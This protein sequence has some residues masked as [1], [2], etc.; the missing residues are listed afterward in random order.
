[1]VQKIISN[2]DLSLIQK[3][4]KLENL[5]FITK[6]DIQKVNYELTEEERLFLKIIENVL[7]PENVFYWK[8]KNTALLAEGIHVK[9]SAKRRKPFVFQII[10]DFFQNFKNVY[11]KELFSSTVLYCI[12]S[13]VQEKISLDFDQKI[14]RVKFLTSLFQLLLKYLYAAAG[15]MN[16][17]MEIRTDFNLISKFSS[18]ILVHIINK[19]TPLTTTVESEGT[20]TITYLQNKN[21]TPFDSKFKLL[22]PNNLPMVVEPNQW[23]LKKKEAVSDEDRLKF[24]DEI[25]FGGFKVN[26]MLFYPGIHI[27]DKTANVTVEPQIIETIN[28]LQGNSFSIPYEKSPD[29]YEF[30]ALGLN[31]I[32]YLETISK[33]PILEIKEDGLRIIPFHETSFF[34]ENEQMRKAGFAEY[35]ALFVEFIRNLY[36]FLLMDAFK[37]TI[38]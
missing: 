14:M 31:L 15:N 23:L 4:T 27:F 11:G 7:L 26:S 18:Q 13:L 17:F 28:Y 1:M 29:Q 21:L 20:K 6:E 32:Q 5:N 25:S 8:G 3:Q 34:H 22:V 9:I 24:S 16:D 10:F 30:P 19:Y 36:A 12:K 37:D 33:T 38:F 2:K 35:K